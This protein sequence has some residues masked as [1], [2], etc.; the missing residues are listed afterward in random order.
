MDVGVAESTLDAVEDPGQDQRFLP[1]T[2]RV[3]RQ[4]AYADESL[5]CTCQQGNQFSLNIIIFA[6]NILYLLIVA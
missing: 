1:L 5:C 4:A 3:R 6:I 2:L